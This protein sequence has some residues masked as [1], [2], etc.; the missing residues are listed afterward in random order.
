MEL[1]EEIPKEPKVVEA[2]QFKKSDSEGKCFYER[3]VFQRKDIQDGLISSG[4][5]SEEEFEL[6]R[7]RNYIQKSKLMDYVTI[8]GKNYP[9][10]HN[11]WIVVA[12][13]GCV[14]QMTTEEF[15]KKYRKKI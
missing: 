4:D 10:K 3:F 1:Y 6:R 9:V 8:E 13:N 7:K 5:M 11:T 14:S 15:K 12:S 2:F